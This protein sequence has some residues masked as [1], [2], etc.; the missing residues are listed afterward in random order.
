MAIECLKLG[1]E[2]GAK[3]YSRHLEPCHGRHDD[4]MLALVLQPPFY[5]A[6]FF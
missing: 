5:K 1:E 3:K 4:L 2:G 6:D